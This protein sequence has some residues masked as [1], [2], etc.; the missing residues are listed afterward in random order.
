MN[1]MKKNS[2]TFGVGSLI[3][4][5]PDAIVHSIT[6]ENGTCRAFLD[7]NQRHYGILI[8]YDV[9]TWEVLIGGEILHVERFADN[10]KGISI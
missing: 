10:I 6:P 2:H 1:T 9:N 4:I 8:D 7:H 3:E 5:F